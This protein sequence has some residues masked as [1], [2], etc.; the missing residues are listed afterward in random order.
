VSDD[1]LD[2]LADAAFQDS[3]HKTNPVPVTRED[4]R[5]LYQQSM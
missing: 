2:P 5:A 3:C 1:Q 4:L